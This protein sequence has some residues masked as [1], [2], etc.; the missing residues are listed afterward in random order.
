MIHRV[1]VYV[2]V[3]NY[4]LSAPELFIGRKCA[5]LTYIYNDDKKIPV[6]K[7]RTSSVNF[8]DPY[9]LFA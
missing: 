4:F 9:T 8:R 6:F 3:S 7:K 1:C 5:L 2:D